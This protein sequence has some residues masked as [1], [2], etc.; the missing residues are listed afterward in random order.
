MDPTDGLQ[1][2]A[3]G[4]RRVTSAQPRSSGVLQEEEVSHQGL[5]GSKVAYFFH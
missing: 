3:A 2:P 5:M 4:A 1:G